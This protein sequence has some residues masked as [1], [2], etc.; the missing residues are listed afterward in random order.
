M[1]GFAPWYLGNTT[2][3][4]YLRTTLSS[5]LTVGQT[6]QVGFWLTNGVSTIHPYGIDHIGLAFS[7]SPLTQSCGAQI[8]FTPQIEIPGVV[9]STTWQY[10]TFTFTPTQAY[11][12]LCIGNFVP[13]ASTTYQYLGAS[14]NSGSYYY[15]DDI[16]VQPETVMPVE[17]VSFDAAASGTQGVTCSWATATESHL[18][19][20]SI[21]RSAD[22][23]NFE[24]V[25][26]MPAVGN[27]QT[28]Q[29]YSMPD[30]AAHPGLSYYRLTGVDEDGTEALRSVRSVRVASLG[31][32]AWPSPAD[33]HVTIAFPGA[34]PGSLMMRVVDA[35]GRDMRRPWTV[36]PADD[37][38]VLIPTLLLPD[39]VYRVV[40]DDARD[41]APITVVVAHR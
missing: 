29:N 13:Y 9:Y 8:A 10:F 28:V 18:D 27:S 21:E 15:I 26:V 39:G 16:V 34:R 7:T 35:T 11:Q 33:D 40:A 30:A 3:R 31:G 12:Y 25:G 2:F 24:L 6:Y 4:E 23:S 38:T 32:M 36:E 22:G 41:A 14:G 5:A 1:A 19:Q 37:G 17:L 20:F